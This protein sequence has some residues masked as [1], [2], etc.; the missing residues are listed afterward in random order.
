MSRLTYHY[1]KIEKILEY[2]Q[3]TPWWNVWRSWN[4]NMELF[5]HEYRYQ[6]HKYLYV[7]TGELDE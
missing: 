5:Y 4:L 2:I 7:M 1:L 6:Y 3:E